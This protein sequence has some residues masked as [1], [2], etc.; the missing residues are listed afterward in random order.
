MP[1]SRDMSLP[2][3]L[4]ATQFPTALDGFNITV[5]R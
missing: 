3:T 2:F 1:A 4:F 5:Y